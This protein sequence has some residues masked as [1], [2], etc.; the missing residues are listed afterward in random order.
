M[1]M[2]VIV[3]AAG[4][5]DVPS[6]TMPDRF[7]TDIAYFMSLPGEEG[8]PPLGDGEYWVRSS[9]ARRWLDEGVI[10]LVSPLDSHHQTEVEITEEQEDWLRWMIEHEV[11][12]IRLAPS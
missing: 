2:P 11:Q 5:P 8:V 6:L 9:D 10:Y 1:F 12:Q 3:H 7:R 4:R